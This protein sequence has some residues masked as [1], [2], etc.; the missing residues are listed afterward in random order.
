MYYLYL[1]DNIRGWKVKGSLHRDC[2][3]EDYEL[4]NLWAAVKAEWKL[5]PPKERTRAYSSSNGKCGNSK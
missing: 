3:F 4:E 1:I 2:P 5:G